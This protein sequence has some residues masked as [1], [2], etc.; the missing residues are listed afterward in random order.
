M[1]N[2]LLHILALLAF[3]V[4][5]FIFFLFPLKNTFGESTF[6]EIFVLILVLLSLFC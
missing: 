1:K 6:M 4:A 2:K 5:S 3:S